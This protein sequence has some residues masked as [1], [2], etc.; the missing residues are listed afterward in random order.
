[1]LREHAIA[2][3]EEWRALGG[4]TAEADRIES[5][6]RERM[7]S[8]MQRASTANR[9]DASAD[10]SPPLAARQRARLRELG[11][12]VARRD[13]L[14]ARRDLS[15]IE[16]SRREL[17]RSM[18]DVLARVRQLETMLGESIQTEVEGEGGAV[19]QIG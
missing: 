10:Q 15:E 19:Q 4:L 2:W 13:V 6:L 18:R 12:Q 5:E 1:M 7:K 9:L 16:R 17:E 14:Q 3:L 11:A 8:A